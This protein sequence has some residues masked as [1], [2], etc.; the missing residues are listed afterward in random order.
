MAQ[1]QEDHSVHWTTWLGIAV[2]VIAVLIIALIVISTN[3][4]NFN[5]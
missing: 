5:W 3:N 4:S 1:Q 2:P